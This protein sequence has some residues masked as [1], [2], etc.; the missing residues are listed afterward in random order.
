MAP[1][2]PLIVI[3]AGGDGSRIGGGKPARLLGGQRLIDRMVAW[4]MR[5]SDAVALA[6]REGTGDWDTGLPVLIDAHTG[7]GPISALASAMQ[8]GHRLQRETV[9]LIGCDLPFLPDDLIPRLRAALAG[10]A[11]ALPVS[12][13]RLHPMAALWRCDPEHL[14]QWIAGGGQSLWRYAR[15]AGMAEVTWD[16][17]PDPYANVN[18]AQALA[19]AERRLRMAER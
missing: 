18:D 14:E 8:E 7:I 12:A 10:H 2:Q 16:E 17:T 11:A 1:D 6:V 5:H 3:A 15:E 13:G 4:A 9:L 19:A